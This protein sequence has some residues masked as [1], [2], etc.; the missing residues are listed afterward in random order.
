MGSNKKVKQERKAMGTRTIRRHDTKIGKDA[1]QRPSSK[2][3]E[4]RA[5]ERTLLK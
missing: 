4:L 3:K 2:L 5:R 1:R